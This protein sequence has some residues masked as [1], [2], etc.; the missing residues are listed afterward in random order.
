[1]SEKKIAILTPTY[2]RSKELRRL[3]ETLREQ[4]CPNFEWYIV[5]DGS[6]DNTADLVADFKS[7]APFRIFYLRKDNGGKHTAINLAMQYV[8]C[9]LTFIVDSDDWLP[10]TS[11]QS[12]LDAF[13]RIPDAKGVCGISF[14]KEMH[15]ADVMCRFPANW[16]RGRY[17]DV[18]INRRIQGDKAEV[19]YTNCL[20]EYPFPVFEGERFYHEDGV[21][22]RMSVRYEMYYVNEVVYEGEYLQGGLTSSNRTIKMSSPRGMKD[23]SEA[24]LEYPGFVNSSILLKHALLWDIYSY[25]NASN[26]EGC[27]RPFMCRLLNPI[28][29]VIRKKWLRESGAK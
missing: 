22:A 18:R 27:P 14:L 24:F 7:V 21:W 4:T 12:I 26:R 10:P 19:F 28:A 5:D 20:R 25:G 13:R 3:F 29:W 6:T 17:M 2:N 15:N 23:R 1:M 8:D 11:I 16:M 9:E